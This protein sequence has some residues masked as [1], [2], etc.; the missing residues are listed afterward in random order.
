M[1]IMKITIDRFT[2]E[3]YMITWNN[4]YRFLIDLQQIPQLE[5]LV[6]NKNEKYG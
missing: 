4:K 1:W 3:F 6:T 5:L 2:Y